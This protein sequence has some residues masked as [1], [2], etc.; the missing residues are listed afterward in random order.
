MGAP[1][2]PGPPLSRLLSPG[3]LFPALAIA[4]FPKAFVGLGAFF[5]YDTWM[6]NFTFRAGTHT[7]KAG[8]DVTRSSTSHNSSADR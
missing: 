1:E 7:L 2:G 3:L 8:F 6:Q 5:H 4:L